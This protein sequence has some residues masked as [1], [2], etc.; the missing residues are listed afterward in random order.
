MTQRLRA[1]K[2][3]NFS[4]P[5]GRFGF[6]SGGRAGR[7]VLK[8]ASPSALFVTVLGQSHAGPPFLFLSLQ[9]GTVER[10]AKCTVLGNTW[11]EVTRRGSPEAQL[12]LRAAPGKKGSPPF[13]PPPP[14]S[15]AFSGRQPGPGPQRVWEGQGEERRRHSPS[16]GR[17][18]TVW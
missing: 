7:E 5:S 13:S 16:V 1:E 9:K 11:V 17:K 3:V 6:P 4:N 12:R 2:V 18:A 8:N 10:S 15:A 14:C